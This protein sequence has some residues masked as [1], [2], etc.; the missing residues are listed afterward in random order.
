MYQSDINES[1]YS[2]IFKCKYATIY[3]LERELVQIDGEP[4]EPEEK[5]EVR[6]LPRSLKVILP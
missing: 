4:V 1:L 6:I 2:N 5:L 3:N